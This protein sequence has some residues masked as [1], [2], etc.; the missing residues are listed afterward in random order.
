M[1]NLKSQC[2]PRDYKYLAPKLIANFTGAMRDG[3]RAME[4]LGQDLL[5]DDGVE[6]LLSF[7]RKRLHITDLHL[8]TDAFEKY[9]THLARKRGET[10][11]KYI[12][13]EDTAHR[14][15]QRVLKTATDDGKDDYSDDDDPDTKRFRLP[16]RLRGWHFLERA[17]T[18][19]KEHSGILNQTGGMNIDRLKKVMAESL[20]EKVLKDIDGRTATKAPWQN[21]RPFK[22]NKFI[23]N[24]FKKKDS[25]NF[26]DESDGEEDANALAEEDYDEEEEWPA[27][28][29]DPDHVAYVDEEGWFYADE[30]TI[31]AVD[32]SIAY[33]DDDYA[34]QVITYTEAR[35]ALAKARIARGFYPVVVPAD[36]GRQPRFGRSN[37][38]DGKGKGRKGPSKKGP[39]G[40]GTSSGSGGKEGGGNSERKRTGQTVAYLLSMRKKRSLE[41][42]LHE[43]AYGKESKAWRSRV[44]FCDF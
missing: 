43:R 34:N 30:E 32:E 25:T 26:C 33:D 14:K 24:K 12:N 18:P 16:K 19:L 6:K 9:F 3:A 40:T 4:L 36:D 20:P 29:E 31:N 38:G 39:T 41:Q 22:G 5:D 10:L 15:L 27:E 28:E 7:I 1:L 11:M 42:K 37:K 44:S 23:K 13:E 35:N 17:S 8:E 21:P 2:A